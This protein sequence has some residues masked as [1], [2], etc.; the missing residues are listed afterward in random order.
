MAKPQ[1]CKVKI[2]H[3]SIDQIISMIKE[4]MEDPKVREIFKDFKLPNVSWKLKVIITLIKYK[5]VA[6]YDMHLM[7][8]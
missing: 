5:M 6:L 4:I 1:K 3:Y 7:N 2:F 8:M